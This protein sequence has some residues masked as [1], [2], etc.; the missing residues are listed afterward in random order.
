MHKRSQHT[1]GANDTTRSIQIFPLVDDISLLDISD[2]EPN[3]ITLEE[4]CLVE[5][6]N[7]PKGI[8]ANKQG[9]IPPTITIE[10]DDFACAK[11]HFDSSLVI[12]TIGTM[13]FKCAI[14]GLFIKLK[15]LFLRYR[16]IMS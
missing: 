6:T 3:Q 4:R 14:D 11:F 1:R 2:E 9:Q 12:K 7:P 13:V 5:S 15:N 8:N 10:T 16:W